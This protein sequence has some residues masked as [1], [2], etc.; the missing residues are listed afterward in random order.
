MDCIDIKVVMVK[1]DLVDG[2]LS[3]KETLLYEGTK[4]LME[5]GVLYEDEEMAERVLDMEVMLLI[6]ERDDD[7]GRIVTI[8]QV[9]LLGK[10]ENSWYVSVKQ[11][12]FT[13]RNAA[14]IDFR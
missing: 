6:N 5:D 10:T 13:T 8:I 2:H 12:S 3:I 11:T 9:F 4:P 7:S 14:K 1:I